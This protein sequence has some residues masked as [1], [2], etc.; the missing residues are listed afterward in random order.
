M[1]LTAK[2]A[3]IADQLDTNGENELADIFRAMCRGESIR[4]RLDQLTDWDVFGLTAASFVGYL[5]LLDDNDPEATAF[6]ALPLALSA[7]L[8]HRTEHRATPVL[9]A[10]SCN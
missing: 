6:T 4:S 1:S 10:G 7:Y 3:S 2:L 5:A 8:T 9:P